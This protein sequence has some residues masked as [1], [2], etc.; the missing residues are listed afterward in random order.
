MVGGAMTDNVG[1]TD[2][3]RAASATNNIVLKNSASNAVLCQGFIK[4]MQADGFEITWSVNNTSA[5]IIHYLA[6]GGTDVTDSKVG[7][8]TTVNSLGE[9]SIAG[10][11]FEPDIVFIVGTLNSGSDSNTIPAFGVAVSATKRGAITTRS[12][13][14][15]AVARASTRQAT[16]RFGMLVNS[17]SGDIIEDFD[18]VSMDSDGFTIDV[19][20]PA[21]FAWQ[22]LAIKGGQYSVGAITSPATGGNQETSGVGFEPKGLMLFGRSEVAGNTTSSNDLNIT[23]GATDG[24]DEGLVAIIDDHA[25]TVTESAQRNIT[26]KLVSS[27]NDAN[28]TGSSTVI[29]EEGTLVSLDSD[30]FT[31]NWTKVDATAREWIYIAFGAEG[32]TIQVL[33]SVIL[34]HNVIESINKPVIIKQNLKTPTTKSVILKQ[35]LKTAI[36]KLTIIKQKLKTSIQKSTIL[37]HNVIEPINKLVIIK[38]NI[39]SAI[40]K[41]IILKHNILSSSVIDRLLEDGT[42]RLQEDGTTTRIL[43]SSLIQV[44]KQIIFKHNIINSINKQ[45]IIKQNIRTSIQKLTILK[46]NLKSSTQKLIIIKQNLKAA[47]NKQIIIKQNLR[48]STQKNTILKQNL[49][50]RIQKQVI[51]KHNIIEAIKKEVILKHNILSALIQ[52]LKSVILKHNVI[53]SIQKQTILKQNL[54]TSTTKSTIIKQNIRTFANKQ[55]ILKQNINNGIQKLVIVKQNVKSAVQKNVILKQNLRGFAQKLTIL[56]HNILGTLS[57]KQTVPLGDFSGDRSVS[58]DG[59]VG[60]DKVDI[61]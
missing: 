50:G 52:V 21:G 56:K 59:F 41:Q 43:E 58:L 14:G 27:M 55:V 29:D 26:T 53:E 30:G 44:L 9:Q 61:T 38:Q 18:F 45:T 39:K 36:T 42:T 54:K 49:Q 13:T 34:K 60:K 19:T 24:T 4:A 5:Y 46:Q 23:I 1:T 28:A 37:K 3:A 12:E 35:N 6:I 2:T 15:E 47:I 32:G 22:Y 7:G 20:D 25:V 51:I 33:K 40:Q 10:V 8:F 31:I 48:T 17:G 11:G 16:N 57:G